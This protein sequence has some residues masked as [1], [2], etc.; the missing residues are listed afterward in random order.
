M[1]TVYVRVKGIKYVR[2]KG[3]MYL[4][5]EKWKMICESKRDYQ[6]MLVSKNSQSVL[7]E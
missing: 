4:A 2:V 3:V 6:Y 5:E 7:P 1:D